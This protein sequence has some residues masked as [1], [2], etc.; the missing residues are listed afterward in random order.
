MKIVKKEQYWPS[1]DP[2]RSA[3]GGEYSFASTEW[4]WIRS[5]GSENL[6]HWSEWTSAE[7]SYCPLCGRF[8]SY[9]SEHVD[10]AHWKEIDRWDRRDRWLRAL[11][12]AG[13]VEVLP[14]EV[15]EGYKM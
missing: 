12:E 3:N 2:S 11:E 13:R 10:R 15:V 7:F 8:E 1:A 4:I 9:L 6:L 5:D 14:V